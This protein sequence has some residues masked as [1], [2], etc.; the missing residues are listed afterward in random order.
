LYFKSG[1]LLR[2]LQP[3]GQIVEQFTTKR[4]RSVALFA[5]GM[6]PKTQA[7]NRIEKRQ[8]ITDVPQR[9]K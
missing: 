7:K 1:T 2:D 5:F 6:P 9:R 3:S 4:E 8:G